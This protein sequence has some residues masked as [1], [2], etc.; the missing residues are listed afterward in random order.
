[1]KIV[2][3]G[4]KKEKKSVYRLKVK[5]A[6]IYERDSKKDAGLL[7]CIPV[8]KTIIWLTSIQ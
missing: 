8:L 6:T 1:M 3:H 4:K 7:L 5:T 2:I